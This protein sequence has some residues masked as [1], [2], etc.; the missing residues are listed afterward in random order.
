MA[1]CMHNY[2]LGHCFNVCCVSYRDELC[3][4]VTQSIHFPESEVLADRASSA[5]ASVNSAP[6]ILYYLLLSEAGFFVNS[7]YFFFFLLCLIVCS[8]GTCF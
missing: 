5:C 3:C 4:V 2:P 7:K 8:A 1:Q 6:C